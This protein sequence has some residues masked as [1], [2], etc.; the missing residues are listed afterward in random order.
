MH[1]DLPAHSYQL[2]FEPNPDWKEFY[3]KGEDLLDYWKGIVKKYDLYEKIQ[4]NCQVI[5]AQYDEASCKWNVK[6]EN[7]LTGGIIEDSADVFYACPGALNHWEWPDITGLQNFQG[8]LIHSAA[9]NENWDPTGRTVAVIGAGSSAIQIIPA[10]Q[11]RVKGL[12]N[13][14]RG[15]VWIA[16]PFAGTEVE[17]HQAEVN[18]TFSDEEIDAFQD[19][20]LLYEYRK[21][22]LNDRLAA[23][24]TELQSFH[25]VTHQGEASKVAQGHFQKNMEK[26]LRSR[27]EILE[28]ILPSF[29]PGCRRLT[30]GPGYLK[31]LIQPNVNLVKGDI[32]YVSSEGVHLKDGSFYKVDTIICATGFVTNWIPRFPIIGR[33]GIN[34]QDKWAEYPSSY[35]SIATDGFPNMFISHGPNSAISTGNL[36]IVLEQV[37]EY[38]GT[39]ITKMQRDAVN[40]IEAKESAVQTFSD[41]CA[42]YFPHTVF[43]GNCR[44]WYKTGSQDGRISALWPGSSL[45][46]ME[47]LSHPRWEDYEY[48][49]L[50]NNP[51]SW[52]GDGW[53]EVGRTEGSNRSFYL[54][55]ERISRLVNRKNYNGVNVDSNGMAH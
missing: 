35:L 26:K 29:P 52:L 9:W 13:F 2:T 24:E 3:A 31:S 10:I 36:M 55:D 15:E 51:V 16:P 38:V 39:A 49:Y 17:K 25:Q 7:I 50:N 27:P 8:N 45:H 18:F 20:K 19:P 11:G 54:D 44:S 34:L 42:S 6:I 40:S 43:A 30:P 41:Y 22:I 21:G 5:H 14:M 12:F 37:A 28:K 46:A 32:S 47:A 48:Q 1:E 4:L 53:T 33:R 23:I